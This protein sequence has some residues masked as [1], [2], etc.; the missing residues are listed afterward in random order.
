[1]AAEVGRP[2]SRWSDQGLAW[3][4]ENIRPDR[5]GD[6]SLS[7]T[8]AG[9]EAALGWHLTA[10]RDLTFAAYVGRRHAGT[11]DAGTRLRWSF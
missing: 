1:M 11:W 6:L 9:A 5:R 2:T 8:K 3:A 10:S 4:T 7:V